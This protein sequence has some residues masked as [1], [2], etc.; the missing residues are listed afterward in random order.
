MSWDAHL[1]KLTSAVKCHAGLYGQDGVQ[2]AGQ[3]SLTLPADELKYI[4]AGF[5]NPNS[6]FAAGPKVSGVKFMATRSDGHLI[7]LKHGQD[8][9]ICK[10]T[11]KTVV[12]CKFSEADCT[13]AQALIATESFA[14]YLKSIHF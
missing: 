4:I 1:A 13:P 6:L 7:V 11:D 14:D 10:K 12:I 2:W 5:A 3:A 9:V 8:G